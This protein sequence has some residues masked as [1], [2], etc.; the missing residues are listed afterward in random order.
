MSLIHNIQ[1]C[2]KTLSNGLIYAWGRIAIYMSVFWIQIWRTYMRISEIISLEYSRL[3]DPD[4][5]RANLNGSN[6]AIDVEELL[7]RLNNIELRNQKIQAE[8]ENRFRG[9]ILK[10][11][12]LL[13]QSV[14]SNAIVRNDCENKIADLIDN[15]RSLQ[16]KIDDINENDKNIEKRVND[17][18][19]SVE[20]CIQNNT[21]T[22]KALHDEYVVA[23][24]KDIA[25]LQT[26]NK[27]SLSQVMIKIQQTDSIAGRLSELVQQ[28]SSSGN[29]A[30]ATRNC[31]SDLQANVDKLSA[32]IKDQQNNNNVAITEGIKSMSI[33]MRQEYE[34]LLGGF[35]RAQDSF[36][37]AIAGSTQRSEEEVMKLQHILATITNSYSEMATQIS[38]M[39][40]TSIKTTDK[41]WEALK[42]I[43]DTLEEFDDELHS[44]SKKKSK[45]ASTGRRTVS[46]SSDS[47]SEFVPVATKSNT[48]KHKDSKSRS[49]H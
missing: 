13:R 29:S 40:R 12:E 22:V 42:K 24:K 33:S 46:V 37:T 39:E 8:S 1:N 20:T 15:Q 16:G 11:I 38:G 2:G 47:G 31:I 36:N 41:I 18:I 5:L 25:N 3:N 32:F 14:S 30:I 49:S 48:K 35:G 9:E 21:H 6:G 23:I 34:K 45:T 19:T 26:E 17:Y 27:I 44:L 4:A 28:S 10:A 43:H 7:N